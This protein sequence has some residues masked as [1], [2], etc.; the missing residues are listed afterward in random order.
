[1][2]KLWQK[3]YSLDLLMQH[4]TVRNDY[5]LDQEL[6]ISDVVASIAHATMLNKINILSNSELE[7]LKQGL[8]EIIENTKAILTIL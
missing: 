6:L 4:F 5:I 7:E 8:N 1:M 2:A 3:N